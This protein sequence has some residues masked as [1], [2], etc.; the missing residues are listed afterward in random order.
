MNLGCALLQYFVIMQ[1][2]RLSYKPKDVVTHDEYNAWC[3]PS[4]WLLHDCAA[5]SEPY[6]IAQ[7]YEQKCSAFVDSNCTIGLNLGSMMCTP[8]LCC[9]SATQKTILSS[10]GCKKASKH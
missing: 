8:E 9:S 4:L 3:K 5:D 7:V 10:K 1:H 6:V 2:T